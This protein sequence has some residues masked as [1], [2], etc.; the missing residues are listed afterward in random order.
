MMRIFTK[1]ADQVKKG[2]HADLIPPN[3]L[4]RERSTIMGN[5]DIVKISNIEQPS[6]G[7]SIARLR[8]KMSLY[9]AILLL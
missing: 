8:L 4:Q 9:K 7:P 6:L 1:A 3:I 2:S 5:K